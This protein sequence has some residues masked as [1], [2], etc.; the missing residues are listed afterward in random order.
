VLDLENENNNIVV[1][2]PDDIKKIEKGIKALEYQ[3][4]IDNNEYDRKIHIYAL[5]CYQDKFKILK[6][7]KLRKKLKQEEE[8]FDNAV[9]N[10]SKELHL[11]NIHKLNVKIAQLNPKNKIDDDLIKAP[12]EY[13]WSEE[14]SLFFTDSDE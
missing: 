12:F 7:D 14:E 4:S 2:V 1:C 5:N 11:S 8:L 9:D 3:I 13:I 6:L 10:E